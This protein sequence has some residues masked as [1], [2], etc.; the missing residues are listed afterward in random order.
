MKDFKSITL[1]DVKA[2]MAAK[3]YKIFTGA[4]PNIVG[5]RNA[6]RN[7]N[8][9]DDT[10]FTW[11]QEN[12]KEVVHQYTITTH[13]GYYY[14][15]KPIAGTKGAAIVVP[16]QYKDLWRLGMHRKKQFALCQVGPIKVYRDNNK[17]TKQDYD[18]KTIE[19]GY[20]GINGH[21][22]SETNA[23]VIGPHSAGCQVW[24]YH[25]PH[26]DLMQDFKRLS[27]ANNFKTF[28][29]TLLV[30]EDFV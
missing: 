10:C 25:Q 20:F 22:A 16:G 26:I 15:L 9:F 28:S 6:V 29:Y 1:N 2:V 30:Q 5:I 3:G 23:N 11:W 17:D 19:T 7:S 24:R 18:P 14:L 13:P 12:G 27:E 4:E 21:R 8:E